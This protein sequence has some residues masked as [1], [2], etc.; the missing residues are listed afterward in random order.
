MNKE[1]FLSVLRKNLSVLEEGEIN[2]I[3]EEYEQHIDM[4][5]KGGLSEK[6]A[7]R[8][9]G[10]I[11]ELTSGILEAYHVKADF[12]KDEKKNVDFSKVVEES[13]KA[14]NAIGKGTTSARKWIGKQLKRVW[15]FI[16]KPF[17]L[18]KE[19]IQNQN[20]KMQKKQEE[21]KNIQPIGFFG[22][23]WACIT[24]FVKWVWTCIKHIVNWTWKVFKWA[25]HWC[26][27]IAWLFVLLMVGAG[28][29]C[30]IFLFGTAVVLQLQKYPLIGI[31]VATIGALFIHVAGILLCLLVLKKKKFYKVMLGLL[32][33]GVLLS[34]IGVGIAFGEYSS[35]TYGGEKSL[36]GSK[37]VTAT[38]EYKIE[39]T[40]EADNETA[41]EGEE[42]DTEKEAIN[43]ELFLIH[44]AVD[45]EV[46][47][48]ESV[49]EDTLQFKAF[50]L[51]DSKAPSPRVW[52]DDD[53][54]ICFSDGYEYND[55]REF[56]RVK[57]VLLSDIKQHQL[58]SYE[59]DGV[60]KVEV[61][62]N[63]NTPIDC[64]VY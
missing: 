44:W 18:L 56:M 50:Y 9:F 54:T 24:G 34:G 19:S 40:E 31:N 17:V 36:K 39:K 20:Q 10:D 52:E 8:D 12:S 48:D 41:K 33:G 25:V 57:D 21:D 29:L 58:S 51:T 53:K 46:I 49:P 27:R 6:D 13:K 35:F 3:I 2:D 59:M 43:V 37:V 28:S 64:G 14:T 15:N 45:Y 1:E 7:I 16:K 61:R 63:P 30:C 22:R 23:I 11:K 38:C 42:S 26:W 32:A 60:K 47:Q 62:V 5:M 4:K 55:V